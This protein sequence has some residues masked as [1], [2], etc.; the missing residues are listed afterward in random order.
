MQQHSQHSPSA[1]SATRPRIT[2]AVFARTVCDSAVTLDLDRLERS[3]I[4]PAWRSC[5]LAGAGEG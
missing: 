2:V 1:T 4:L 5:C 3:P